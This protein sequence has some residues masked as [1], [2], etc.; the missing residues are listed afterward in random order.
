MTTRDFKLMAANKGL[1]A[2]LVVQ[3]KRAEAMQTLLRKIRA[4]L[5][6]LKLS[7]WRAELIN[8]IDKLLGD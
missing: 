7:N 2:D 3:R 6:V 5:A 8:E 4:E 1:H